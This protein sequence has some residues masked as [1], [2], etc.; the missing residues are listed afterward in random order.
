MA[1]VERVIEIT[2]NC[3]SPGPIYDAIQTAID[4]SLAE[5]RRYCEKCGS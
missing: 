5:T 1:A 3:S 2:G 4:R